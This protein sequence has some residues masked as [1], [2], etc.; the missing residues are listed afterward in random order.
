MVEIVMELNCQ[1]QNDMRKFSAAAD[2]T[3]GHKK[4]VTSS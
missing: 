4:K 2:E 3:E 1:F